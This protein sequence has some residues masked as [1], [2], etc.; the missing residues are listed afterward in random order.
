MM[1][2]ILAVVLAA[3]LALGFVP[4]LR[5]EAAAD[6]TKLIAFTFDDGPSYYTSQLLDGLES[7]GVVATFFMCG[8]N[9]ASGTSN[10]QSLLTRMYNDGCQLANHTWDHS[11]LSSMSSSSIRSAVSKVEAYLFQAVG[12]QYTDFVRTPG[13]QNNATIRSSVGTP[14]IYWSL[15]TEDW[16]YRNEDTVY[17]TIIKYASDGDIVILHDLY[18]T[19]VKAALRAIDTLKS[20]GFEFVTVTELLRRRGI[21]AK[22][23]TVYTSAASSGTTL[24]AYA[25]P[26]MSATVDEASRTISVACSTKDSGVTLYYTLDGTKPTLASTKYEGPIHITDPATITV[27]GIDAYA[28]RTPITQYT[29]M[30]YPVSAPTASY[31]TDTKLV[32][33]S[34]TTPD[35]TIYYTTDGSTPT[36]SS[37]RYTAPIQVSAN[38]RSIAVKQGYLNSEVSSFTFDIMKNGAYFTDVFSSA[39]YFNAVSE[40]VADGI[41]QGVGGQLFAP[42]ATLTRAMLTQIIYNMEGKPSYTASGS[43]SDVAA[44][45]WY[46]DAIT[47]AAE[48]GI[49][50]GYGGGRFGPNDNITREQLVTIFYRYV[51]EHR[52]MDVS[53]VSD[54]SSYSDVSAISAYAREAMGWAVG[55]GLISGLGDGRL[56]PTGLATRA[57]VAQVYLN[58]R[59]KVAP[60]LKPAPEPT[61]EPTPEP[62]SEEPAE[63]AEPAETTEPAAT[64]EPVETAEPT[65]TEEP[66]GTEKPTVTEEPAESEEPADT[67]EPAETAEPEA[68]EET[69]VTAEPVPTPEPDAEITPVDSPEPEAA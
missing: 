27:A 51:G 53:A 32:T 35:A 49:V 43:F 45:S 18:P 4:V 61:A 23:G 64:E 54:L 56:A 19:S 59:D 6:S 20:K 26:T 5:Q 69:S 24:P 52:G 66:T 8:V 36:T 7:R 22:A 11:Y 15:D 63:S 21:T 34:T 13:G 1:K 60:N 50:M 55:A 57:Q 44:G 10:Y 42:E 48:K 58:Y 12:G 30:G 39:W 9:G 65:M 37:T 68:T 25:A 3:A 40:T 46:Y 28:T 31:S 38:L 33:L 14:I 47:W 41:M 17:N 16:R 2:K 29:V 67:S 62:A